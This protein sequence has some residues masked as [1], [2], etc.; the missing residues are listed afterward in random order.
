MKHL[1]RCLDWP[2]TTRDAP[3]VADAVVVLGCP[4]R[5]DGSL[6]DVG[7]ERVRAGVEVWRRGLAPVVCFTGRGEA[8]AMARRAQRLG[9]PAALLR[10]E[11]DAENTRENALFCA[12][13]LRK[14]RRYQVWIVTQ[15]FHMRR[16]QYWFRRAGLSPLAW[17][18]ADSIEY[19][20]A[21]RGLSWVAR[22]YVSW[23]G[24]VGHELRERSSRWLP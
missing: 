12:R 1:V 6:S 22:E 23:A 15:P 8:E 5:V 11:K 14:E 16:A 2:L 18:I 10:V 19:Q 24:L 17:H 21:P 20:S 9:V 7:E 4:C 13:L 3:Q